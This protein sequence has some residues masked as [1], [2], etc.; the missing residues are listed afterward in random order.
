MLNV[1]D[2]DLFRIG[3]REIDAVISH[4]HS[5][6][7]S[8]CRFGRFASE[9]FNK[10][11]VY[12]TRFTLCHRDLLK[13]LVNELWPHSPHPLPITLSMSLPT[14]SD[15]FYRLDLNLPKRGI[16]KICSHTRGSNFTLLLS[17][18]RLKQIY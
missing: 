14:T 3:F 7:L 10:K 18:G 1:F 12:L 6:N 15:S 8:C 2:K 16:N 13:V 11:F 9:A 17:L 5:A 4:A